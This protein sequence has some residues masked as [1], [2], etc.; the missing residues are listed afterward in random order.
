MTVICIPMY[1]GHRDDSAWEGVAISRQKHAGTERSEW[2][3]GHQVN[4]VWSRGLPRKYWGKSVE[5]QAWLRVLELL[6]PKV[7]MLVWFGRYL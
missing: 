5:L 7:T 4:F 6:G 3:G 1:D 2:R